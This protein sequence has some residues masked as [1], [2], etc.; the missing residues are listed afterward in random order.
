MRRSKAH[1]R[2]H[3]IL[4]LTTSIITLAFNLAIATLAF[5]IYW[6]VP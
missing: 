4:E 6:G 5:L 3:L 2:F 1:S